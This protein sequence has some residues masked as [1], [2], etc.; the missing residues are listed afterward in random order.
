MFK[1]PNNL[2]DVIKE[3]VFVP[4]TKKTFDMLNEF[5]S[6]QLSIA[7]VIDEFGGTA[8]IVTMEDI[9]EELFG[10]IKDEYDIDEEICRRVAPNTYLISGKVE[11]D[12]I[13]EKYSLR[14]SFRRL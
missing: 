2:K 6:K 13:N 1:Y 4:E 9:I 3:T 10:E 11:I 7:I 14:N 12:Y 5:L 8:G